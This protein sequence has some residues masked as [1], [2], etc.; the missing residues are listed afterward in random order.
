MPPFEGEGGKKRKRSRRPATSSSIS[1]AK[2]LE[3]ERQQALQD[4]SSNPP[5]DPPRNHTSRGLPD[6]PNQD[7]NDFE[8]DRQH[9]EDPQELDNDY[10]SDTRVQLLAD[11]FRSEHYKRRKLLEE[12]H[13]Q[14]VYDK[15]FT[16]FHDCAT[17]TSHWGNQMVWDT[18]WKAECECTLTRKRPVVLVDLLSR[19][20]SRIEFCDCQ[21]DQVRLIQM[22]YIGGAPKF[23]RTAFSIRLLQF[24]HI[25]WK[26]SAI[27]LT[28]FSKALDEHLDFNSPLILVNRP[29]LEEEGTYTT[30]QW[31]KTLLSAIDAYREMLHREE[32]LSE[33]LLQMSKIDK[34]AE[35]CPKCFGPTVPGK[36]EDEPDY[37]VCM[38]GN[39]QHRRHKAASNEI[40]PLKTPSLFINPD[41]VEAMAISMSNT[42]IADVEPQSSSVRTLLS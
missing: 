10:E 6:E 25:V 22:G 13:W 35:L 37:I 28:P 27:A 32:H 8:S 17:K 30:R 1:L 40:I 15:L 42:R 26:H 7:V 20:E 16:S 39:F 34:L 41:E 12:Q 5:D 21:P 19:R 29:E 18:D 23:P 24:H 33:E 14:E 2:A 36:K 38:D 11:Y 31:R 9:Y 3:L 4:L